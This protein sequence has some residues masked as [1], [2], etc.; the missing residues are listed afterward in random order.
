MN[1]IYLSVVMPA[2]NE[3]KNILAAAGETLKAFDE[4]KISGEILIVND[5]SFDRTM[6]LVKGLAVKEGR[7]RV[8]NHAEPLGIGASFWNGV[9]GASGEIVTMFPGD[10]EN[11]PLEALRYL[12]LLGDVDIVVPFVV[13]KKARPALRNLL[14][15]I[16]TLVINLTFNTS[17]SYTN[18]TVLYR[19]CVLSGLNSR[20]TGFFYQTDILIR[21]AKKGYLFAEVPYSLGT[22][23]AGESKAVS[24]SSFLTVAKGY[25]RL[26]VDLYLRGRLC[27]GRHKFHPDSMSAKRCGNYERTD[28]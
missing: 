3:E 4:M 20:S 19:K 1:K 18:G 24:A 22:R 27:E 11:K 21:L 17:F 10:N 8:I 16:Y 15:Y 25:F 14:S 23:G 9:D 28:T 26:F 6:E 13:N 5:G 12:G 2:L 7:V